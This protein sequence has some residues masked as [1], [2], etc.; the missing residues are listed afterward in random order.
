MGLCVDAKFRIQALER[1]R[2]T[3]LLLGTSARATYD[4]V[5]NG[6]VDRFDA[7]HVATRR[8]HARLHFRHRA[9]KFKKSINSFD[10]EIPNEFQACLIVANNSTHKTHELRRRPV[11][12]SRFVLHVTP[13]PPA[14]R[15]ASSNAGLAALTIK[16]YKRSSHRSGCAYATTSAVEAGAW[17]AGPPIHRKGISN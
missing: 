13:S 6:K 17:H 9:V 11:R 14:Q 4:Y 2:P 16:R 1:T 8:A 7:L 3:L 15:S 12:H 5:D 10:R